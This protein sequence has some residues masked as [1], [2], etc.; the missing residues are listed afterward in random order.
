M[1][2]LFRKTLT[3]AVATL[4]IGASILASASTASA[5]WRGR[6]AGFGGGHVFA[7]GGAHHGGFQ[8][9][10]G[11]R[12]WGPGV[13]AGVIGGL[14]LGAMAA[15]AAHNYYPAPVYEEP[16]PVYPA[17]GYGAY[18]EDAA[19]V[20]HKEWRPVYRSDGHYVRDRQVTICN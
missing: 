12:G 18:D 15:G 19:P 14:A 1:S 10:G 7:R 5:D 3:G 11:H 20:C 17:Y 2:S 8:H 9:G 6:G 4:A 16:R 13:A